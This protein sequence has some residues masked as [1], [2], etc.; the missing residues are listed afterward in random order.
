VIHTCD[1]KALSKVMSMHGNGVYILPG[2]GATGGFNY[3]V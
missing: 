2:A 1:E 3:G